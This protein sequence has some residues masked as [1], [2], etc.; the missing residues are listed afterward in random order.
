M[1]TVKEGIFM[2][3]FELE[4]E[5][6]E[7]RHDASEITDAPAEE[8]GWDER[9]ESPSNKELEGNKPDKQGTLVYSN[10]ALKNML[11]PDR[12]IALSGKSLQEIFEVGLTDRH[13][14]RKNV[15]PIYIA[16]KAQ[17]CALQLSAGPT[18]APVQNY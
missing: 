11:G 8:G 10:S 2:L 3:D 6:K 12:S 5:E 13:P 9:K 16:V 18:L 14:C 1:D 7:D 15:N 4:G 17:K